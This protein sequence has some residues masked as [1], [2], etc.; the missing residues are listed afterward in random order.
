MSKAFDALQVRKHNDSVKVGDTVL[1]K[2]SN[3][4]GNVYI[5]TTGQARLLVGD[6]LLTKIV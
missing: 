4:E 5:K 3:I 6:V 1:Y 2:K